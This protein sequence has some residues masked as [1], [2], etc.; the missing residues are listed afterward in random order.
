MW[1]YTFGKKGLNLSPRSTSL[2]MTEPYFNFSSIR[3]GLSEILFEEYGFSSV[4]RTHPA[5][6]SAYNA[7][8]AE[9]EGG[10]SNAAL[11]V[12][13]GYSFT[14]IVPFVKGVRVR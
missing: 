4:L 1:D 7:A 8:A 5:D 3:E 12:D 10:A 2:V 6:L 9:E 14:H 11:V 13:S